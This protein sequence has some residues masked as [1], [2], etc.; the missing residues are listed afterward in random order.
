MRKLQERRPVLSEQC[1]IMARSG[2]QT[3]QGRT[4]GNVQM[5]IKS[6]CII[7]S[8]LLPG[9]KIGDTEVSVSYHD[10]SSDG[11]IIYRT[12]IHGPDIDH[13]DKEVMSRV[14]GGSL[15]SGLQ[16][17]LGFLYDC[18]EGGINADLYPS[19]VRDWAQQHSDEIQM[20]LC[21]LEE[22]PDA[23]SEN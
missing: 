3:N 19:H 15:Q 6:P 5:T 1:V 14:G 4:E 18:A 2:S 17:V 7:T 12:E 9:I 8:S 22:T 13:E 21:V 16:N 10:W 11:R 20:T 23:I